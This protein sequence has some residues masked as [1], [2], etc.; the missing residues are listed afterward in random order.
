MTYEEYRASFLE[1]ERQ[2]DADL[3]A[4]IIGGHRVG[5]RYVGPALVHSSDQ[6]IERMW[7]A[8]VKCRASH[9]CET[10]T[11]RALVIDDPPAKI[12]PDA[13]YQAFF[14]N[15][16]LHDWMRLTEVDEHGRRTVR[17]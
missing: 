8:H 15:Y 7:L 6:E 10:L 12:T 13:L 4:G 17:P 1:R 3:R 2:A 5:Y 14:K 9:W 11:V 16:A